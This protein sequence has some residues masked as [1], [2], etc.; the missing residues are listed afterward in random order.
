MD[1]AE[2]DRQ[3]AMH[4]LIGAVFHGDLEPPEDSREAG[5][6]CLRAESKPMGNQV[7][8]VPDDVIRRI[9]TGPCAS[10]GERCMS[11]AFHAD[12]SWIWLCS[13]CWDKAPEA[14]DADGEGGGAVQMAIDCTTLKP[15]T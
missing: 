2:R 14:T 10:C 4:R 9:P 5:Q 11:A 12:G 7:P 6:A 8:M 1:K 15:G 13:S 3:L